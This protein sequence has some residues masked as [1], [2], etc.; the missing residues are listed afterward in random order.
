ML[1]ISNSYALL[2]SMYNIQRIYVRCLND[3]LLI[4]VESVRSYY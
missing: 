2:Y 4:M 1:R 3:V